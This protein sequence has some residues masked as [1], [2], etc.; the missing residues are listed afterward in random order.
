MST[1]GI[2]YKLALALKNAGFP[3]TGP[4]LPFNKCDATYVDKHYFCRFGE[5]PV[6][7]PTLEQ[8]IDA[9][10]ERFGCLHKKEI[11]GKTHWIAQS[12]IVNEEME[13]VVT[14]LNPLIAVANLYLAL[15]KQ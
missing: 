12:T 6:Y 7:I 3:Q 15:K 9:C 11:K 10:G 13:E 2:D 4:K 14:I 5:E 8:L 1:S